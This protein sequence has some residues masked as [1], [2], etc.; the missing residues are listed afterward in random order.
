MAAASENTNTSVVEHREENNFMNSLLIPSGPSGERK[1][2][3][4]VHSKLLSK[5]EEHSYDSDSTMWLYRDYFYEVFNETDHL[6]VVSDEAK[7]ILAYYAPYLTLLKDSPSGITE[8]E[9]HF[10]KKEMGF[11]EHGTMRPI[12]LDRTE[13]DCQQLRGVYE[14]STKRQRRIMEEIERAAKLA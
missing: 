11:Y 2:A 3:T 5:L 6:D 8:R 9:G 4:R 14:H 7:R 12:L 13:E 1:V 10:L